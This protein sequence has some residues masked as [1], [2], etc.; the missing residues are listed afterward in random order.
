MH[1]NINCFPMCSKGVKSTIPHFY[2]PSITHVT[3]M[4]GIFAMVLYLK[5][6]IHNSCISRY[7]DTSW[8]HVQC[9]ILCNPNNNMNINSYH[10][11]RMHICFVP[12]I[13]MNR[14]MQLKLYVTSINYWLS[15]FI[16]LIVAWMIC[17]YFINLRH[18]PS[19][20]CGTRHNNS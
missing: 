15:Q 4:H 7:F 5:H 6:F 2:W 17:F 20:L 10:W 3:C 19:N 13:N 9:L 8:F 18:M 1:K 12:F 11:I 16:V 14:Q